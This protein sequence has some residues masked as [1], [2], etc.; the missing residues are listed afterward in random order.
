QISAAP[1]VMIESGSL[2][3][4][5]TCAITTASLVPTRSSTRTYEQNKIFGKLTWQ[6]TPRLQLFQTFNDEFWVNPQI[7]TQVLPFAATQRMHAHVPAMTFGHLTHTLS[8]N[9][10]WDVRVGR[11]V[12]SRYDDPAS[13]DFTTPNRSDRLTGVN[14]GA[15]Q[16]IGAVTLIRTTAKATLTHYH[17]GLLKANHE[18][19]VGTQVE[20]GLHTTSQ[21]IPTGVRF[22]D[23]N[24]KP[25]RA[26]S[27]S[28]SI[29][30]AQFIST[31][32]FATDAM[33]IGGRLTVN[34][35]VR[36]D[37]N[38]AII[39]DLRAVDVQGRETGS[40][41]PG[42]G[43]LFTWNV[44]SPRLGVTT[45]LTN[46]GR[47]VLRASY[48]RFHQG[49]LTAEIS[50]IHP[51]VTPITTTEFDPATGGYTRLISVVNSN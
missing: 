18:W 32:F 10:L 49:I 33:T 26:V 34:A 1:S 30:G 12:F 41:V 11:F 2:R 25:F 24:G 43:T 21:I 4:I 48:G 42:L 29:N 37:K 17:R 45:K 7:P 50:P 14:S 36:F 47:T 31:A 5:S 28:P 35:G 15:P 39:Q 44:V 51:G 46:D 23:D 19:K 38:R 40:I 27:R 6:L 20:K 8:A 3:D 13:G 16:L 9:T 22:I